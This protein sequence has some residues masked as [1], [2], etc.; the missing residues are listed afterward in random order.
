[1]TPRQIEL[2]RAS[3]SAVEPVAYRAATLF[4]YQLFELDPTLERLFRKADMAKQRKVL[5]QTLAV[6]VK[7]LDRIDTIVPAV[8]ALGR[9][10]AG[11]GV[12]AEHYET[13]GVALLWT[14]EQGLGEAFDEETR[15][16]WATAY[17][18]LASVMIGAAEHAEVGA[19]EVGATQAGAAAAV[20][21]RDAAS[22]AA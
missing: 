15:E 1:M 17:G 18:T 19:T 8:E 4:Y 10:H 14:L 12:R 5:M 11:Y 22:V 3:W 20:G 9:Q 7:N 16:A 6:V 13:V 2:I 21:A